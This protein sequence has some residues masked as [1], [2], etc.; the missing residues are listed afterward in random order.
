[1]F[2]SGAG[3]GIEP[4]GTVFRSFGVDLVLLDLGSV[5]ISG[6]TVGA[7]MEAG[8]IGAAGTTGRGGVADTIDAMG[9]A[10]ETV[11]PAG[12]G[13]AAGGSKDISGGGVSRRIAPGG[14]A[15]CVTGTCTRPSA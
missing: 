9:G 2:G 12:V 3:V 1:M 10:A 4:A 13:R 15:P 5:I 6:V 8:A 14:K 11:V 7:G